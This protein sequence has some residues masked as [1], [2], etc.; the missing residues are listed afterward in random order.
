[1]NALNREQKNRLADLSVTRRMTDNELVRLGLILSIGA[2]L[3]K[4]KKG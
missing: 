4:I 2:T 3:V 1:M